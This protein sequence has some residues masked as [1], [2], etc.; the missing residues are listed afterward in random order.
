MPWSAAC[1]QWKKEQD[2]AAV[3]RKLESDAAERAR[4]REET[5]KRRAEKQ[6]EA[7]RQEAE[8][9]RSEQAAGYTSLSFEDFALDAPGMQG[10][11]VAVQ[12]IYVENGQRLIRD[13]YAVAL[14]LESGESVRGAV[15]PLLIDT[16]SRDARAAFLRCDGLRHPIGCAMVVRG[17]VE[18]L[19]LSN[20]LGARRNEI[21][22]AVDSIR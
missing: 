12:G 8:A 1:L 15:I 18:R 3:I 10:A 5:A 13:P 7:E 6:R 14:W 4:L 11:R 17:R 9:L 21:G 16:A 2:D 22:I 19:T 20:A